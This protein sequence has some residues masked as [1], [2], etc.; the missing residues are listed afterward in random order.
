MKTV[1]CTKSDTVPK[2]NYLT[3]GKPVVL[4]R[5]VVRRLP[6]RCYDS[7]H[8]RNTPLPLRSRAPSVI[9]GWQVFAL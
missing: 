9:F 3:R 2:L 5:F 6:G 7:R 1:S 8:V 4:A